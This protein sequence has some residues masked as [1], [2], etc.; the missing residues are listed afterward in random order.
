MASAPRTIV[1]SA[2]GWVETFETHAIS[3][4]FVDSTF[5]Q[6]LDSNAVTTSL[7]NSG[8][9]TPVVIPIS[10]AVSQVLGSQIPTSLG[11]AGSTAS[12]EV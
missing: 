4:G 12:K 1:A 3:C 7:A 11:T 5:G 8:L 10:E 2:S 6:C 9:S